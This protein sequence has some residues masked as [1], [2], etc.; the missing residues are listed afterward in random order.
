MWMCAA[1]FLLLGGTALLLAYQG[2]NRRLGKPGVKVVPVPTYGDAGQ[3]VSTNS[4]DLPTDLPGYECK[5]LPISQTV[6]N[7]LPGD[8][9]Y[10]S[11]LYSNNVADKFSALINVVLMGKD[12]T[13]LHKPEYCLTGVGWVID[14][15]ETG[16]TTIQIPGTPGY[17]L[18]VMRMTVTGRFQGA[19]GAPQIVRGIYVFWFVADGQL[20]SQHNE[21]MWWMARD[22]VTRGLLQRWA[23]VSCFTMCRPGEEEERYKRVVELI[24]AAVPRFQITQGQPS[25]L[26]QV[27]APPR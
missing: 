3:V 9:V 15:K 11:C 8:T 5:L 6:L 23:Y 16:P 17:E 21:R 12:R 13:S 4:V 20:T 26:A 24:T 2:A 25:Q 10:G 7:W 18:P 14:E 22:L 27:A 1:V 19:G